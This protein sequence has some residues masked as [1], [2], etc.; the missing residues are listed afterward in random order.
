ML[1]LCLGTRSWAQKD[2]LE[3]LWYNAEKTAKIDIYKGT[4]GKFWGKIVWL[5]EPEKNGKPKTDENNPKEAQRNAPL[6]GLAILRHFEKD[7]ESGYKSGEVYDPKNGK[8]YS[9]KITYNNN[10]TLTVR[11]YVG[12]SML[13]RSTTWEKAN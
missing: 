11:G 2:R 4:D 8:L 13:G 6:I 5:K 7:G 10:N 9:C 1:L 12:I 3:G